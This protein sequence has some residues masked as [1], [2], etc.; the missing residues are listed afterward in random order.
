M[1]EPT[2]AV[3]GV[4]AV[5]EPAPPVAAVYHN[6]PEPVAVNAEAVAFWQYEIGAVVG[7]AGAAFTF[8]TIAARGLSGQPF[9]ICDT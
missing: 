6:K 7:A 2:V 1:V 3:L 9:P 8:T 5:A 4:G